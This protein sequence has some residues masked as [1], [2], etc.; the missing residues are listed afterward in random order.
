MAPLPAVASSTS[1]TDPA[2]ITTSPQLGL[3]DD[4][5]VFQPWGTVNGLT[6]FRGNPTRTFYGTGPLPDGLD[7]LWRFPEEAM[8]GNSPLSGVNK[9]WCGTGWTG[10]PVVWERPDGITEVIFGA[11]DKYV[12]FLDA[13]TGDRTR[14]DFFMGDIIKG[15]VTLDPDGHPLL[16]VGSRDPRFRIIALDR[17]EP[18]E[19]WSLDASSVAGRWN[20][21]WDS[22]AVIVDGLLLEGGENSWWFAVKLNRKQDETG[23]VTV[24]PEILYQTPTWT[25]ELVAAIGNQHSVESSTAVFADTAYFAT[26]AGRVVGVDI[27][28]LTE[29]GGEIVFDYWMG[30]DVDATIVI[31][32]AGNL[33]VAAEI[34]LATTRGS[35]VGQLVKLDPS[36]PDDPLVWSINVPGTQ[37]LPGGIWATPALTEN[38][39]YALTNPGELLAVDTDDGTVVWRD[40][41]GPHA[42]SSPVIIDDTLVVAIDCW[43]DS[44]FRA[45]D[46]TDPQNPSMRWESRVT[47]GCI[48]STPA[49][50]GGRLF[51]GSRDGFFYSLGA[52]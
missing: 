41:V 38:V 30:D 24:Q 22:S 12:H 4:S 34:D 27:S 49:V 7:V 20:N 40:D 29:G 5:T 51:V 15:S 17:D 21:D 28:D 3:V 2:T 19:L 46:V 9:T 37:S 23:L 18:T 47:S 10:Q 32:T 14:P 39:L 31:D 8:C 13:D 1:T 16:Y 52:K 44:G 35:E 25:D 36:Q 45:Y 42:W 33:Y 11:Y 26:G 43:G 6:M 50:W 48:E